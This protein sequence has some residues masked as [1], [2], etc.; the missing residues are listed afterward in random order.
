MHTP[1]KKPFYTCVQIMRL[2]NGFGAA[3]QVLGDRRDCLQMHADTLI[4]SEKDDH[5]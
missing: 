1:S 4:T 5:E 3:S 2:N